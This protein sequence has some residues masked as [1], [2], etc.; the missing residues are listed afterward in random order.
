[1]CGDC[2]HGQGGIYLEEW[3]VEPAA[4][5]LGMEAG[6]FVRNYCRRRGRR[7]EVMT[8]EAGVCLLLGPEGCKIHAAKPRICRLWP[9]LPQIVGDEQAFEE[10]R[11]GCPGISRD[12]SYEEFARVG[13]RILEE[14]G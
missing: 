10:A 13:R 8:D 5:V 7:W 3:E 6:E 1:M 12:V 11:L 14:E 2:C 4:R 9:F